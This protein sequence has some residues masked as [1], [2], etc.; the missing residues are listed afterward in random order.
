MKCPR[1][2]S[3]MFLEKYYSSEEQ[4]VFWRC[5]FCGDYID[6]VVFQNRQCQKEIRER[7]NKKKEG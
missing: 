2:G 5:V 1:C 3:A 7:R 4:A 6:P